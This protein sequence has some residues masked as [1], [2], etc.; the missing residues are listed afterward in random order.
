MKFSVALLI[1]IVFT[2]SIAF[3]DIDLE[4]LQLHYDLETAS[5][6]GLVTARAKQGF[7]NELQRISVINT[8]GTG[9]I[10]KSRMQAWKDAHWEW[11]NRGLGGFRAWCANEVKEAVE[12]LESYSE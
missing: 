1:A 3:D 11:E 12:R 7:N 8:L 2:S 5:Y 9:D 10:E 4:V 6:C